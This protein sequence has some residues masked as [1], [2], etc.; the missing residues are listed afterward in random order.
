MMIS[1]I[2]VVADNAV[3]GYQNKMP[4]HLPE[5]LQH[6]KRLT[7]GK[8][9]IMGRKTYESLGKPLPGRPNIVLSRQPANSVEGSYWVKNLAEAWQQAR[10]LLANQ[11]EEIM[12]I[13]GAQI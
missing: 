3:M 1:L 9:I 13:G 7:W 5:D 8:P 4:W 11:T 2:A 6:F 12:V 10:Q